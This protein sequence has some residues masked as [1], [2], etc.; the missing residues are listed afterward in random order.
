ML[1]LNLRSAFHVIRAVLP[2]MRAE[3]GADG[4]DRE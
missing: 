4:S 2:I 1:D 3:I